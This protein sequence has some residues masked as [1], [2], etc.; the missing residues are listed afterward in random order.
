VSRERPD[1]RGDYL[2]VPPLISSL[3][4]IELRDRHS[5]VVAFSEYL[6]RKLSLVT[7]DLS[8]IRAKMAR[9]RSVLLATDTSMAKW[10]LDVLSSSDV[11]YSELESAESE[12]VSVHI[13][14]ETEVECYL[15]HVVLL[16]RE[17]SWREKENQ[18][19]Y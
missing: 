15:D 6:R 11:E 14:L 3:D 12:L 1:V 19:N 13:V 2:I 8:E 7:R 9:R 10:K 16:S 18:R 5:T 4:D 17:R